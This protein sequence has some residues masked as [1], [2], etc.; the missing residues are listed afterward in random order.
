MIN[1]GHSARKIWAT[2]YGTFTNGPL[3]DAGAVQT[4]AGQATHLDTAMKLW[5]TYDFAGPMMIYELR[6]MNTADGGIDGNDA[7]TRENHFGHA[8]HTDRS[9]KPAR[10][11]FI[12]N[13]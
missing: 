2:E 11:V 7:T 3:S 1:N 13:K 6:D 9:V 10:A 12:A 8:L 4:E 5:K